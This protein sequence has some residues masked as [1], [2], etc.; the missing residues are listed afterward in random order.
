METWKEQNRTEHDGVN[1]TG[2]QGRARRGAC[3]RRK[4]PS[5][6]TWMEQ[7]NRTEHEQVRVTAEQDRACRGACNRRTGQS[8]NR[9]V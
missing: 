2:E 5:K 7:E 3:N 4:G 9:Y 6:K 8:M 1:V